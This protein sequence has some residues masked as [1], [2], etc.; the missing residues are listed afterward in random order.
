MFLVGRL[1]TFILLAYYKRRDL[2]P[3]VPRR[4]LTLRGIAMDESEKEW[5]LE[6][7]KEREICIHEL[8]LKLPLNTLLWGV[9]EQCSDHASTKQVSQTAASA[10]VELT[11]SITIPSSKILVCVQTRTTVAVLMLY[12]ETC[13]FYYLV[14]P[15][16]WIS[17]Y[18]ADLRMPAIDRL[19]PYGHSNFV[20]ELWNWAFLGEP[21]ASFLLVSRTSFRAWCIL[22]RRRVRG[23]RRVFWKVPNRLA[24]CAQNFK[25]S[26]YYLMVANRPISSYIHIHFPKRMV[27]FNFFGYTRI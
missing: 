16:F 21:R 9:S 25:M 15:S 1:T 7:E 19:R 17:C 10:L 20:W 14:V 3:L 22:T 13:R 5:K 24:T 27:Y 12:W 26:K 11:T 6:R 18:S 8:L 23:R 4:T 2:F